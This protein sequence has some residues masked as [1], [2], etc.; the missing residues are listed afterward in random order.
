MEQSPLCKNIG[1]LSNNLMFNQHWKTNDIMHSRSLNRGNIPMGKACL[2]PTFFSGCE[3]I[4]SS[5]VTISWTT[6]VLHLHHQRRPQPTGDTKIPHRQKPMTCEPIKIGSD[7][8][9]VNW[10]WKS[11][12]WH[13]H[14]LVCILYKYISK[15]TCTFSTSYLLD[16]MLKKQVDW[17]N[18][19]GIIR[20]LG[21]WLLHLDLPNLGDLVVAL[22]DSLAWATSCGVRVACEEV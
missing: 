8:S 1:K 3:L 2:P 22:V 10:L 14:L 21:W 5:G 9:T 20:N 17:C 13:W 4:N 15:N 19:T 7:L 6:H 11:T 18:F 16:I 12:L